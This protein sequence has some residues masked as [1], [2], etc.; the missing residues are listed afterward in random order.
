M[1]VVVVAMAIVAPSF[2]GFSDSSRF[3]DAARQLVAMARLARDQA[4][5]E[6]RIYRMNIDPQA[7]TYWL[8]M[9]EEG[10]FV[11]LGT[12]FGAVFHVPQGTQITLHRQVE[13]D[14]STIDFFPNGRAEMATIQLT[15]SRGRQVQV[16]CLSPAELFKVLDRAEERS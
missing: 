1:L 15:D 2:R 10:Q 4:V 7:G 12:D 5:T 9:Q 11:E 3:N 8:T 13:S 14:S 6:G 16:G